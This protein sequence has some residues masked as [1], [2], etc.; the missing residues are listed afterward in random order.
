MQSSQSGKRLTI[1]NEPLLLSLV[2]SLIYLGSITCYLIFF[3]SSWALWSTLFLSSICL[4]LVQTYEHQLNSSGVITVGLGLGSG[5][6]L[7]SYWLESWQL[8]S[9]LF[10]AAAVLRLSEMIFFGLL[11]CSAIVFLRCWGRRSRIGGGLEGLVVCNA[12]VQLFS[13]HRLGQL[14]EPRFFSDWVIISGQ[15][16]IQWWLTLFGIGLV[17][18]ALIIFSRVRRMVHLVWATLLVFLLLGGLYLFSDLGHKVKTVQP[19]TL[20]GQGQS[21]ED[22]K[23]GG[24]QGGGDGESNNNSPQNRPPTPVAVAVFHDDYAPEYGILYFR[25]QVLSSF[26]GVKLV[27]DSAQKFDQDV[28]TRFPN[29][30]PEIA[31]KSQNEENH[32]KVSTSMYLIDEHPTPPALTNAEQITPVENPAPQRFVEAYAVSSLVSAVPLKRYVG[33]ESIPSEWNEEKQKF[34]LDTHVDDP[35]YQTLAEEIIRDLPSRLA[36]DPIHRAIAIKRY[37]EQSGYYTLKVKHRS[38]SDPAASFL[39]G[40]LRGYCV[41]FAH[42]AVHLLRSQGIAARVALGYAVDART[43]SNSSAVLI[44]GDRAHAWPEIHIEGV[45]WVTFDIYPE[46]SDDPPAQSVSQSLESLFGEMARKQL[47]RGLKRGAPFPWK[48]LTRLV[49][50]GLAT[51]IILGYL[52]GLW[53]LLRLRFVPT[54][55]RGRLA[56]I[57]VLDRL[58]GA[59]LNR[60]KGETREL[61]AQRLNDYAPGL[62]ELTKIHLSWALGHPEYRVNRAEEVMMHAKLVRKAYAKQSRGKWL[63]SIV[64]PFAWYFAR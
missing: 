45:G 41:H 32:L 49:S 38:S 52:I 34:Y 55:L 57:V 48:K 3:T 58:A 22:K 37:L 53:R 60:N 25:Q 15:H 54:E 8:W 18:I 9:K 31:G 16:S 12:V 51:L 27:S 21:K 36:A 62:E 17:F 13:T 6:W 10:G 5:A 42:S 43:R 24:G 1:P 47:D 64:N 50:Y 40:D 63:L 61:Y 20:G 26:D 35:R 23:D 11:S 7:L 2:K 30:K 39:F 19:L 46:N 28:L 14:H 56:Y 29:E 59:G 33:R 4:Y 44:T